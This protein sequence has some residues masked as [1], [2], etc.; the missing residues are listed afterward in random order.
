MK[1]VAI[2]GGIGAGKSYVVQRLEQQGIRVFDCDA[3]AKQLMRTSPHLRAQIIRLVG[4][5]AYRGSEPDKAAIAQFI[6]SNPERM[7]ALNDIV[8]PAV[9]QAFEETGLQWLE[10]AILFE[11]NFHRRTPIDRIVC[12]TAPLE[13]R[14]ARIV[15]RDNIT[16][17]QALQWIARQLPQEEVAARSDFQIVNDGVADLDTQISNILKLL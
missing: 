3:V 15:R 17:E 4:T 13:M 12:V 5:H 7:A 10:S 1:K 11:S 8:H 16:R 2:T 6:L 14:I 9:A